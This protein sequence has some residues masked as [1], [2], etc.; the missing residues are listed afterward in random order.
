MIMLLEFGGNDECS[1]VSTA[2]ELP[3]QDPARDITHWI[4]RFCVIRL[5]WVYILYIL[6]L[7]TCWVFFRSIEIR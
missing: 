3:H 2:Q 6:L 7:V 4:I 1:Y 5:A